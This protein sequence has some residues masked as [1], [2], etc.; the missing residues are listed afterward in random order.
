MEGTF[1]NA[2]LWALSPEPLPFAR[3]VK[4]VTLVSGRATDVGTITLDVETK[5]ATGPVA[6]RGRV[7][8]AEGRPV[9]GAF[10][11]ALGDREGFDPSA[12]ATTARDGSFSFVQHLGDR[13]RLELP[14]LGAQLTGTAVEFP[15]LWEFGGQHGIAGPRFVLRPDRTHGTYWGVLVNLPE[16]ATFTLSSLPSGRFFLG[17]HLYATG[18][19]QTSEG[20]HGETAVTLSNDGPTDVGQLAKDGR[21]VHLVLRTPDGQ[22]L[23]GTLHLRDRMFD[24]WDVVIR[25]GTTH[26]HALDAIPTPPAVELVDGKATFPRLRAGSVEFVLYRPDGSRVWFERSVT[27]DGEQVFTID[28]R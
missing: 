20:H 10:L 3:E 2:V 16:P 9:A 5:N 18:V 13:S 22:P 26:V 27:D 23:T 12:Y 11:R 1:G 28:P 17:Q 24:E 8:D 25:E 4:D 6:L 15:E 19:L 14:A 7:L 21:T